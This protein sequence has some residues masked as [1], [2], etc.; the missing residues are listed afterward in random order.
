MNSLLKE[1]IQFNYFR[2]F[3]NE[4]EIDFQHSILNSSSKDP[5][6]NLPLFGIDVF[7]PKMDNYPNIKLEEENE[8]SINL[9][10]HPFPGILFENENSLPDESIKKALKE[11]QNIEC[12]TKN[13]SYKNDIEQRIVSKSINE[14]ISNSSQNDNLSE[15]VNYFNTHHPRKYFRVDD[16]K[17]H[18]KVAISQF[19]TERLNSLIKDSALPKKYKK[20]IHL[21][22]H[23]LF[24]SNP[25]EI[26]NYQ[27]LSFN[28]KEI[29][30]YGKADN[31]LQAKNEENISKILEYSKFPEKTKTIKEFLFMTYEDIIKLFYKSEK[32]DEFKKDELTQ[33]FNEGIKKEKNISLLEDD[34]L[35]RLFKM[36]KKKRKRNLFSSISL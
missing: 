35:V 26:D 6:N 14:N 23:K 9:T 34:G 5:I 8:N 1:S 7:Y 15:K 25:K 30:T 12:S 29:F 24:S 3:G 28:V 11:E 21:P 19:A 13:C 16:A 4:F 33:F 20:K 32:F 10:E 2:A 18:F 27:F 36:T 17:K 22:H 31:N